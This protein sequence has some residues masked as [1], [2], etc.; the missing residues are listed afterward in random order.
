MT[1]LTTEFEQGFT[2]VLRSRVAAVPHGGMGALDSH[3]SRRPKQ[4]GRSPPC[5]HRRD[6][7]P[8]P[9]R[10]SRWPGGLRQQHEPASPRAVN[11][12]DHGE[13]A[14]RNGLSRP[15]AHTA[16]RANIMYSP[17]FAPAIA[18][19]LIVARTAILE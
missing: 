17:L 15:L 10:S 14:F 3:P 18:V 8:G 7:Y 19:S 13:R 16:R 4:D 12:G 1:A 5:R 11:P 6:L 9:E 2:K